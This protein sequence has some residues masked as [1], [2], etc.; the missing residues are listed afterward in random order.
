MNPLRIEPLGDAAL[1]AEFSR[2]L[3]LRTNE[4]LQAVA[5]ALREK[6]PPWLRDVVPSLGGLAL[7]FDPE[8]AELPEAPL[9]AATDLLLDCLKA[10]ARARTAGREVEVPVCYDAEFGLDLDAVAAQTGLDAA[11]VVRL[12]AATEHRVLMVGFA[13]GQPYIG[14]LDPRLAVPRR[15][16]P[17]TRVPA[18][19]IAIANAQSVV[20]PF[21]IAG[22]W[23]V[24][25]RT[26][27]RVF[28]PRR[29]PPSLLLPGDRVRFAPISRQRFEA[30]R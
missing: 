1:Y 2:T 14:G 12:H 20:Y 15:A 25:G 13:P 30:L 6:A 7:H 17:R 11:Q 5:A 29:E 27:L 8:H 9:R 16:T 24:L 19:S 18:G 10:T 3:D 21:E 23:S 4:A 22:G 28:D 26:P